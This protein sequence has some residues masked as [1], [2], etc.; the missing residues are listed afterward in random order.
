[1]GCFLFPLEKGPQL[2]SLLPPKSHRST[3]FDTHWADCVF[4]PYS[5]L[6]QGPFPWNDYSI[7]YSPLNVNTFFQKICWKFLPGPGHFITLN[8][9]SAPHFR[10]ALSTMR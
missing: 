10:G 1:M 8:R 3:L 5:S 7:A 2:R 6:G 9:G 4:P